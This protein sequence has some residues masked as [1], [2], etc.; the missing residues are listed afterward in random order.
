[1]QARVEGA[2]G[3]VGSRRAFKPGTIDPPHRPRDLS[4]HSEP[5]PWLVVPVIEGCGAWGGS[6]YQG[7][8]PSS[9]IPTH[10]DT[11]AT[12]IRW[13][14]EPWEAGQERRCAQLS[15]HGTCS[16]ACPIFVDPAPGFPI[17]HRVA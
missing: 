1:M 3:W 5:T 4:V 7:P 13:L 15:L 16:P 6:R 17:P 11:Q 9:T 12:E 10:T 8:P 2:T 14:D